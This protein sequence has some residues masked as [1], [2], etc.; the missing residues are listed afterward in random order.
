MT[1]V[2]RAV[3]RSGALRH[4][5]LFYRDDDDYVTGV[6]TFVE[7]GL[8]S[9][10]PVL[11]VVPEPR[12]EALR[13]AVEAIAVPRHAV[14]VPREAGDGDKPEVRYVD[15]ATAG[16]NPGWI[17]PGILHAFL[18]E[19]PTTRVR[20]VVEPIWPGRAAVAYP[21]CVQ[22]EALV[23]LA[24]GDEPASILCP[25]DAVAL[26]A[27]VIADAASTHPVL[28]RAGVPQGSAGYG[29]PEAV[30]D[31]F[32]RPLSEPPLTPSTLL[33]DR[34]GMAGMRA[35]VAALAGEA[36]LAPDRVADLRLATNEIA[37]N[38][39]VH[40]GEPAVLRVWAEP[41]GMVC[42]VIG[43]SVLTNRLAGLLP[44]APTSEQG[45]GLLLVNHLC[46]LVHVHTTDESTTVRLHMNW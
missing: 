14:E 35:L 39:V 26:N 44:A 1:I 34:A 10:E 28:I 17:I 16:R 42:E 41:T 9:A 31:A 20:I 19:H 25:Y 4:E 24:L 30:V 8:A 43:T 5:A 12:H 40:G 32:N 15:M 2:P 36:G 29:S 37:T 11:V 3:S 27:D 46:D 38:A 21:R 33:F 23:N 13:R 7:A 18:A 6:R 45:R 22:H